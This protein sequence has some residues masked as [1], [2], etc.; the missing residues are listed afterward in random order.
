M[1]TVSID[2]GALLRLLGEGESKKFFS[3]VGREVRDRA[4]ANAS[5]SNLND[6]IIVVDGFEEGIGPYADVGYDKTK[7]GFSLW[8]T[9]VGTVKQVARPHLRPAL[10]PR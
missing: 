7:P 4:R 1:N 6:A 5:W 2:P 8:W 3:A 9:E 10:E